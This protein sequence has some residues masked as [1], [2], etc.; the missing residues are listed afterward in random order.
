M[1]QRNSKHSCGLPAFLHVSLSS[2]LQVYI[3]FFRFPNHEL[4]I[5]K[6]AKEVGFK[7][8][9]LSHEVMPMIKIVPRGFTGRFN[10]V[11]LP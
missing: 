4:E 1:G 7:N 8:V 11:F 5:R 6:V 10:L 2:D 9:S 3:Q